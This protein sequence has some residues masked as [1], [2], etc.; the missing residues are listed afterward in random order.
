MITKTLALESRWEGFHDSNV[1]VSMSWPGSRATGKSAPLPTV[2]KAALV[3]LAFAALIF[4]IMRCFLIFGNSTFIGQRQ[5]AS[6]S[7]GCGNG[8]D[9][10]GNKND[11]VSSKCG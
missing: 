5:L 7:D 3:V 11:E 4:L 2:E 6:A 10:E 8:G 9:G 1:I